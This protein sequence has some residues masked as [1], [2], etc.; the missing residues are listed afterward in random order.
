MCGGNAC[1]AISDTRSCESH[2]CPVDCVVGTWDAWEACSLSC[3]SGAQTRSRA[4]DQP[5]DFG[6]AACPMLSESRACNVHACPVDCTTT[7]W[8]S[9]GD[10][11]LSCGAGTHTRTRAVTVAAAHG[12]AVCG[13]LGETEACNEGPCPVHCATSAWSAFTACTKTC[14]G[15]TKSRSR[16]ITT[17]PLHGGYVCPFLSET[18]T[19]NTDPCPVDCVVSAWVA[20]GS[21]T[22]SCGGGAQT[23][24]RTMTTPASF[25][26]QHCPVLTE[27]QGC[28]VVDCPV[29]CIESEWSPWGA[30]TT[31]CGTGTHTRS[32]AV[33]RAPSFGGTVCHHL[34]ETRACNAHACPTDTVV[35]EWQA[36]QACSK[37]CGGGSQGRLRTVTT[38]AANG[39]VT[40][41][42]LSETRACN[43]FVWS[44]VCLHQVMQ[45]RL[46]NP[47]PCHAGA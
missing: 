7:P 31:T 37:S 5:V 29:D 24:S 23:R 30:C 12:G 14:G 6:G 2:S 1:G 16:S 3:G 33:S 22:V 17:D 39:G 26:G 45:H 41:P 32:R 10:C 21:C 44:V 35:S 15:G 28:S 4:V 46:A 47:Q 8:V 27:V 20:F 38:A 36:W 18:N 9:W 43:A 42:H 40:A 19:C 11:S 34:S 13:A 25:G